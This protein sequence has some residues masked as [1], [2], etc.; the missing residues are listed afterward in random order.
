MTAFADLDGVVNYLTGGGPVVAEVLDMH[1]EPRVSGAA[2]QAPI[3]GRY[4]SLF[5]YEGVPS[6]GAAPTTGATCDN[7]TAGGWKQAA[8]GG[9]RQKW[10]TFVSGIANSIGT[11]I[12]YDR[13]AHIGNLSGIVTTAQTVG[14]T[15][16]RY[17]NG[18]GVEAWVEI[19]TQIG[20]TS[21]TFTMNYTNDA[22]T[23]GQVSPTVAIGNTNLREAQRMIPISLAA[24]DAGV[25]AVSTLTLAASTTTAGAFGVTLL[26]R[27]AVIPVAA[28][29]FGAARSLVD[30]TMAEIQTACLCW[31]WLPQSTTAPAFDMFMVN[32]E[33]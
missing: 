16:T 28:A 7:T 25:R 3:A 5:Q 19:Y 12:L 21:T 18:A 14:L 10:N 1:K 33:K 31:M 24:G 29:G 9:G 30:G 32:L 26:R 4:T 20:A 2:A 6:H 11:L 22:G 15:P 27:L 23:A 13:L 8:P 17:T